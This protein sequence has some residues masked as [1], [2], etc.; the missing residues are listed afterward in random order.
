MSQPRRTL[1]LAL[2]GLTAAAAGAAG[3][4]AAPAAPSAPAVVS[5]AAGARADT[6]D[7]A[8]VRVMSTQ[9]HIGTAVVS[10]TDRGLR[11][12]TGRRG[13]R[14]IRPDARLVATSADTAPPGSVFSWTGLGGNAGELGA[15]AGITVAVIDTGISDTAA[16]SRAGGRLVDA[17]DTGGGRRFVDGYGH[18]TFMASVIA[19]GPVDGTGGHGLGVAPGATVLNVKVADAKGETSLSKVLEGL[20]WVAG[21]RAT[22]SIDVASLAFSRSRPGSGYGADPLTDAVERIRD[23]GINIVVSAGNVPGQV[24]DPGFDPRVISVGAA[25][26]RERR[27]TVASFSGSG[28]VAGVERPDVVAPGVAVLG[29]LPPD[30]VVARS[31]PQSKHGSLWRGSGTSQAT[32]SAAGVAALLLADYPNATTREVKAS[33]RAAA[34]PIEGDDGAGLVR[35]ARR[36]TDGTDPADAASGGD[37]EGGFDAGSWS[38]GS[39]SAGSWSAGSWSAGS[40]SAGSWSAG[41]WSSVWDEGIGA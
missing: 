9:P 2:V 4:S 39:W 12:L 41:S 29:L 40:W 14:G 23:A 15:G 1:A 5:L 22:H 21:H 19:G 37:G 6:L 30:S 35:V 11:S 25:D 34:V 36:L 24:G 31:Y 16:L 8:G 27:A 32:A 10:A 20:D 3:L 38:A 26:T 18:G 17:V 33:L 13:V 7:V 28:V